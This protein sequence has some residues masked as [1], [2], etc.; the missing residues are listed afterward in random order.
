MWCSGV[1]GGWDWSVPASSASLTQEVPPSGWCASA[2]ARR[3]PSRAP[4][5]QLY[6]GESLAKHVYALSL[7]GIVAHHIR[8]K[9]HFPWLWLCSRF[10][11]CW[12][13]LA[14][15]PTAS[16]IL[17]CRTSLR[18]EHISCGCCLECMLMMA[19]CA[20]QGSA[21]AFNSVGNHLLPTPGAVPPG[22]NLGGHL[23]PGVGADYLLNQDQARL[24]ASVSNSPGELQLLPRMRI[25]QGGSLQPATS[26]QGI[27]CARQPKQRAALMCV[28]DQ[29]KVGAH[30][31]RIL[32]QSL[33]SATSRDHMRL[34]W[35]ML[36]GQELP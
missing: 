23:D 26:M 16:E 7:C 33:F 35:Q 29:Q 18:Q 36:N 17:G 1:D 19:R 28:P 9:T 30:L 8:G 24:M 5:A 12:E 20:V 11:G 2:S 6:A 25:P 21:P 27:A 22:A 31:P 14:K 10:N 4:A 15:T 34:I 13:V 3:L 32:N